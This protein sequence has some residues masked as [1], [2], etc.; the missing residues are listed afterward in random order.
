[1]IVRR[2][3]QRFPLVWILVTKALKLPS[4]L[5]QKYQRGT[6]QYLVVGMMYSPASYSVKTAR[7]AGDCFIYTNSVNRLNYLVGTQTNTITHFDT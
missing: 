7:W 1:M 2:T 4:R 3:I 6:F 5:L